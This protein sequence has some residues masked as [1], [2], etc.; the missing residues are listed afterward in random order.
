[1][2]NYRKLFLTAHGDG[3][4]VCVFCPE[5]VLAI[6]AKTKFLK[7]DDGVVHHQDH[8]R[9]N[10]ELENLVAAHHGCH[11]SHHMTGVPKSA[12]HREK[13]AA[14]LRDR[15]VTDEQRQAMRDG[16]ANMD[17]AKREQMKENMRGRAPWNKGKP[18]SDEIRQK[19]S[20]SHKGQE[21]WNKGRQM[22]DEER[23]ERRNKLT[24]RTC[25]CGLTTNPGAFTRHI[26]ATEHSERR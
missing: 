15:T 7:R 3:P 24:L 13:L 5:A 17:P 16:W 25:E 22:T 10:N 18:W 4:Y 21:A 20:D 23:G 14:A 19:L 9:E 26:R 2:P 8:D 11:V 6:S 12:E 1:M